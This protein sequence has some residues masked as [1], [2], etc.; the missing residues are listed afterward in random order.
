VPEHLKNRVNF[1]G[2]MGQSELVKHYRNTAVLV[3]PS[4]S[5]SFGM[6]LVEAMACEKPVVATRA[7]GMVEIVGDG[8]AGR[9]VDRGDV[10]ALAD[11][12]VGLLADDGLR[13]RMGQAGR[14][15]VIDRF[16]WP[17]VAKRLIAHYEALF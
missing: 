17:Q 10:P 3:N 16:S 12:I 8:R 14:L 15:D 2:G 6:S 1:L 4:Y 5:E 7:G 9:L 11:A 13:A